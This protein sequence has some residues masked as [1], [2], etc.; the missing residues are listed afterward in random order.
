M[1]SEPGKGPAEDD[2]GI[3]N[4]MTRGRQRQR[5]HNRPLSRSRKNGGNPA[6]QN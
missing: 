6:V 5:G 2:R 4:P 3:R 1:K